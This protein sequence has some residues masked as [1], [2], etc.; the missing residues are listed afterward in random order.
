MAVRDIRIS[1][2][3][4]FCGL[5]CSSAMSAAGAFGIDICSA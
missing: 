4:A 3:L 1:F 2:F 5:F